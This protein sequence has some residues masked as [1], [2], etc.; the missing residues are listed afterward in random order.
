MADDISNVVPI[1]SIRA[2][3]QRVMDRRGV[4]AKRL[5]I[6]AGLGET[7]VRDLMQK[8]DDVKL[9]TLLKLADVLDTPVD[10]LLGFE[11]VPLLGKIGAGGAILYE[12]SDEPEMV[13][14][15]PLTQG[16]RLMA[17]EVVGDSMFPKYEAGD[18]VYVRRDHEGVLPEYLGEHC[19]VHTA[20]GGTFLKIL[21]P[22]TQPERFTLRSHNAADMVDVEVLWA[23]P[24][25]WVMPRRS[26]VR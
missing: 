3:L 4:K 2:N 16:Q 18:I 5:S 8:A 12:Q 6:N 20:E 26:R 13:A 19:A 11:D 14:R 7:A 23:T 17:L 1:A 9:G 10:E 24:V 22:G 15:P 25:L 21:T